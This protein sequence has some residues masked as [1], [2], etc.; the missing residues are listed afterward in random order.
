MHRR[1]VGLL[2][3]GLFTMAALPLSGCTTASMFGSSSFGDNKLEV[4]DIDNKGSYTADG[5]LTEARG[6]FRNNNYGYSAAYYKRVVELSPKD[7]EGYI[8][9]GASYDQLRRYDLSDRVYASLYKL[10]GAT[11]QY[12]NN[13]GYSYMLRGDLRKA[14]INFRKARKLDPDNVVVAN[15]IQLLSDAAS[16]R[17]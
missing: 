7:P 5:A 16:K 17:A 13:L 10:T 3:F 9:L 2:G 1:V 12:Y 11:A 14:L 15:N 6:H 4:A 8:G